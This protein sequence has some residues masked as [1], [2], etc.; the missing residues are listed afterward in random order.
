MPV[1]LYE[2]A[3]VWLIYAVIGWCCEVIFVAA[4]E[5][6][7]VNRGFLAGPVCPIYGFGVAAVLFCLWPVADNL[8]LLFIGG[9]MVTS[10]LEFLT[11]F[12]LE[13]I[14][15]EKWW[16]YTGQPFQLGGYIC[17]KF[18]L[19]WGLGCLLV[20]RVV[21]PL[22]MRFIRW[23]HPVAGRIFL[24]AAFVLLAVDLGV[25]VA[26]LLKIKK[27]VRLL[28]EL[29]S[30]IREL[31]D[32]LGK[33]LAAGALAASRAREHNR[34]EIEELKRRYE[35][36]AKERDQKARRFYRAFPSLQSLKKKN[37]PKK[38]RQWKNSRKGS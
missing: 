20:V 30:R 23:L 31:S 10:V 9:V 38:I 13:K 4:N 37:L 29:E 35:R 16:D 22:V 15:H 5:G 34:Q 8:L 7:F 17:L 19:M 32:G 1:D 28:H 25:T 11:G 3:W 26:S 33:N 12:V 21:H 2:W 6:H 27:R 18:S 36:W 24:A 14:F